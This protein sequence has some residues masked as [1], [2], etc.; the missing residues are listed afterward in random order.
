MHTN[1]STIRAH[2]RR[3]ANTLCV[4]VA[5]VVLGACS[6]HEPPPQGRVLGAVSSA[7]PEAT[8]AGLAILRAGG[9]AVDAAVAVAFALAVTEPAGSGLGGQ[10]IF[11]MRRPGEEPVVINGSTRSPRATPTGAKSADLVGRRATTIPSFPAVMDLAWRRFGSGAVAWPTLLEPAIEA[12]E[13][14]FVLGSFRQGS[15]ARYAGGL[16]RD[17]ATAAI[18]LDAEGA[19]PPVGARIV[20]PALARTIR[21]LATAGARDFYAGEIAGLIAADMA[22][23]N[24][25]ITLQ[26]LNDFPEPEVIPA[27]RGSY[28]GDA[29]Y[30]LPP[31]AGG[32]VV[33]LALN[34]LEQM[35]RERLAEDSPAATIWMAETLRAAHGYRVE[36]PVLDPSDYDGA[37]Q[38]RIQKPHAAAIARELGVPG[39]GETTHFCVADSSGLV[40]SVSMSL[41]AYFG[42]KV[43]CP[44]LGILYNDY[45]R[46]FEIGNPGHPFA[47]RPDAMPYSSMS[48]TLVELNSGGWVTLGSPG[49]RRIISAVVQV[50]RNR[51]DR[52]LSL[53]E[54]VAAP[55]MHVIPEDDDL[56]LEL[57]PSSQGLI[58]A[59][60]LRGMSVAVPVSSLV[61]GR[62]NPYFGGVHALAVT[63]DG[64]WEAAADPRRDGVGAVARLPQ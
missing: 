5:G 46:E 53:E 41:N 57:R 24:G 16:Q 20:Q 26:D 54:A 13:E 34:L 50:L 58:R 28:R 35:S 48:A 36:D 25:W 56:M 9:N 52:G 60:E 4:A 11:L 6:M 39:S 40:V 62:L 31:P 14:G 22:E 44:E 12:A 51:L 37:I 45:M 18:F 8:E 63:G 3:P 55:R 15:T 30:S 17:P 23:N 61:P 42:A 1:R 10:A 33:L 19:A 38:D 2:Y 29:V 32:W 43:M 59:L 49:S 64:H 27:L 47:L 7:S 21:R